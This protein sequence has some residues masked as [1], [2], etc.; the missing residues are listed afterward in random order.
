MNLDKL[1]RTL[2]VIAA[3]AILAMVLQGC[4]GDSGSGISQDM[5]DTLMM[6]RDSLNEELDA[7]KAAKD[8]ADQAAAAAETAR[9][10]AVAAKMMADQAAA[11]ADTARMEAETAKDM[12]EA[13]AAAAEQRAMDAEAAKM[14]ADQA[15][16]AADTARMEA[17]AAAEAADTA[18]M[19]AEADAAAALQR[20][21]A[22]EA[23]L[24][25][26]E[27]E[28]ADAA[29]KAA[30]ADRIAREAGIRT[31][32]AAGRVGS[33]AQPLPSSTSGA[34][35]VAATRDAA[36]AVAI[37]VN[38][39]TDDVYAGGE[40]TA[41]ASG[42][43]S[44]T[45]TRTNTDESTDTLMIYTDI[46]APADKLLTEQ[47]TQ[48]QLDDALNATTVD[49]A[50][51]GGF[52]SAPGTSWTYTGAAGE[53]ATTVTGTFDGAPG[54]FMCTTA[55]CTVVTDGDGD[56]TASAGWR[57]TPNSPNEATVKDPDT[58]YAYF[59]WWLNMPKDNDGTHVVE[60]FAGGTTGNAANVTIEILGNATYSGPAAGQYITKTYTAGVQTDAGVGQFTATA[61]L[62]AKFG[63][64]S[65][66]GTIG[67]SVTGF[68]LDG[69][70]SAPWMVMLEDTLLT[71]GSATFN[72]T[73]EV[74]FGGGLT[75]TGVGTWEGS[76]YADADPTD[77]TNAPGAVAGR[78]DAVT[79]NA[80]VIGGF[81]ATK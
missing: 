66:A 48:T 39:A 14:M 38:G 41:D 59:G 8:M 65:A 55:P 2:G 9:M 29:A 53:R 68:M 44:A 15:A 36:G 4:G 7:A 79:E 62:T 81:G 32:V 30:L 22:A 63:D 69:N 67:G 18:R 58:A 73:S 50:Q 12:A 43:T 71:D 11:A 76:F 35:A 56:L 74:N 45:L 24:V 27:Q 60:V 13:D 37:D 21:L 31:A 20:A 34:T 77:N 52:P 1:G 51:S 28:L 19:E 57:F 54:Q 40:V 16:E 70:M 33:V 6:E 47:Y 5:Y 78:F 64:A 3:V 61:N 10:E 75:D 26:R 23:E 72:G 49:K 25:E 80:A 42:W 17:E 46:E